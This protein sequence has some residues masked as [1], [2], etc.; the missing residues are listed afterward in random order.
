MVSLLRMLLSTATGRPPRLVAHRSVWNQ[1][2]EE[3]NRRTRGRC[4]SGAF[5][6]G[7]NK[8]G[9]REIKQF[10]YYDDVDP[11][12]FRRG[13]VEFDGGKFGQVWERCRRLN[14][15]VVAD[16][17]VHPGGY[18]QSR[19]DQHNPMI[20][21]VGHFALILPEYAARHRSPGDI[22]IYE[23]LG[24]R[25]WQDHS[26]QGKQIFHLGWWPK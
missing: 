26:F 9:V 1:G 20:A 2:V 18:G 17:H 4:E 22:G 5:L 21:E 23:Y 11:T 8:D 13:I 10:L 7:I 6:L 14:M 19:S 24:S 25:Q 16:I 15:T 12:C 3:L